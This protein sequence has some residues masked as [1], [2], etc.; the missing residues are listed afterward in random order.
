[1][2]KSFNRW[3]AWW[4]LYLDVPVGEAVGKLQV[5]GV[6]VETRAFTPIQIITHNG[7]IES[8]RVSAMH[9]QLMGATGERIELHNG[10]FC[11]L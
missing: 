9:S 5:G 1:M 10:S 8:R 6:Q 3:K 7:G 2:T 11:M 4:A